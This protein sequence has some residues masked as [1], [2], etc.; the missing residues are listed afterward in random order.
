[1]ATV[2]VWPRSLL[3]VVAALLVGEC[4]L[5]AFIIARIPYTEIDWEAYMEQVKTTLGGERDYLN[6][7][8][9][10]GP[11]VYPAGF[12]YVFSL[13]YYVTGHGVNIRLGQY[14]F[15]GV[16]LLTQALLMKTLGHAALHARQPAWRIA[17]MMI[18]MTLSRRLHSLYVL[19][20]F[21]DC[22]A[23]LLFHVSVFLIVC[24]RRW[25]LA[26]LFF[27]LAVSVKMNILLFAPALL[28]ILLYHFPG[29]R[30]APYLAL[31]AA[32][33]L[34]IGLPFLLE[35]PV[36]YV[37]KAFEFDRQFFFKWSVN[38]Q[39]FAEGTFLSKGLAVTLLLGHVSTLA[40]F[41]RQHW[42]RQAGGVMPLIRNR[43]PM[44]LTPAQIVDILFIANFIG[45]V[46]SR[47][48]HFQFYTWYGH[49]L[50]WLLMRSALPLPVQIATWIAIEV[51][52]NVYPPTAIASLVLQT[53]HALLLLG[54]Y[55]KP[56]P[57]SDIGRPRRSERL[58]QQ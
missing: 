11:L 34:L 10:T 12:L 27:S 28:I 22:V 36:S 9:G 31:C 41:T 35:F 23:M 5:C 42:V 30:T 8:G 7:R 50:S 13:L 54:L 52:Y 48:I 18:M 39:F 6:I 55:L 19:R 46:F 38:F 47:T 44:P 57:L 3:A 45:I 53:C 1:M 33:Q 37:R 51:V 4:A 43:K 2:V 21:N 26:C 29:G 32:V 56:F 24:R 20:L 58:K 14:I 15:A 17:A 25:A 16:Y 40:L 49:H